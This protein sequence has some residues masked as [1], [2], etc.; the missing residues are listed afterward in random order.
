MF[1]PSTGDFDYINIM[2]LLV[3]KSTHLMVFGIL[4]VLFFKSI[5]M[6]KYA[7][8]VSWILAVLYAMTDEWHQSLIPGRGAS[9]HD[10]LIDSMGAL[11]ALLI[12]WLGVKKSH[13]F[14][15]E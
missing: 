4:A 14:V 15:V 8:L 1:A 7:F 9:F 5:K 11:M 10:V 6:K 2:N 13:Q 3:R 12:V